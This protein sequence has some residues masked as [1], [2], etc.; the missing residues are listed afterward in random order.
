[1]VRYLQIKHHD[2]KSMKGKL[3]DI[4]DTKRRVTKLF[5]PVILVVVR[6]SGD[7]AKDR[8]Y[9]PERV[10][11]WVAGTKALPARDNL[12]DTREEED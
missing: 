4:I 1:M 3:P 2:K 8:R 9:R 12:F 6:S 7:W 10:T 11:L 5:A